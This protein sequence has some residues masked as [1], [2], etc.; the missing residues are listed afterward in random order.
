MS[1]ITSFVRALDPCPA[2]PCA[3]QLGHHLSTRS[4]VSAGGVDVPQPA[5]DVVP[6]PPTPH[7]GLPAQTPDTPTSIPP[8][9]P[10]APTNPEIIEPVLPGEHSPVGDPDAPGEQRPLWS[11]PGWS[12]TAPRAQP[13]RA[14]L[15]GRRLS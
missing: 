5:P 9:M 13:L 4:C 14:H 15:R 8:E 2:A 12:F 7:P 3:S 10:P 1:P 11:M 6:L